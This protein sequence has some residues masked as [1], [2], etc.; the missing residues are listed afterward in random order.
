ML[1][2]SIEFI[3]RHRKYTSVLVHCQYGVSRSASVVIAYLMKK[4]KFSFERAMWEVAE[5]RMV[6][7]NSGFIR[8]LK[9]YEK[10]L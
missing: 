9:N 5:K 4:N 7:P 6:K 8:Q 3:D 2:D 10:F 1:D